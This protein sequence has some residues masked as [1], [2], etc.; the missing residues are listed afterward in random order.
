MATTATPEAL[1]TLADLIETAEVEPPTFHGLFVQSTMDPERDREV[2]R[3][4]R[5]LPNAVVT[6]S[7]DQYYV[8]VA[9]PVEG[10]AV[11]F[12]F[13]AGTLGSKR[14]VTREVEEFV[15]DPE[16]LDEPVAS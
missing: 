15:L 8:E 7:P 4:L 10:T 16:L 2:F 14:T 6:T 9:V 13:R 3:A 12:K 11:V 5:A 1:R